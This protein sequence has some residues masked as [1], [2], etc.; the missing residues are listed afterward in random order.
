MI[1]KYSKS[2]NPETFSALNLYPDQY[3]SEARKKNPDW[4]KDTMDYFYNVAI[5]QYSQNKKTFYKNYELYKGILRRED[6]YEEPETK[7]FVDTLL[8]KE[9]L[10]KYV[11]HYSILTPPVN[12]LIGEMTKR[13]D[14][15]F[16]KAFDEEAVNEEI[17]YK[18]GVLEQLVISKIQELVKAKAG[19]EA[20]EEDVN[21]M[22]NEKA[23]ELL[24]SFTTTAEKWGSK[25]LE[26]MKTRFHLKD[27]SEDGFRDLLLS[28]REFFHVYEDNSSIGL[29]LEVINP[30]NHWALSVQDTRYTSDPLDKGVGV[31]AGGTVH[32]MELSEIIHK[33]KLTVEEIAHLKEMSQQGYLIN[34]KDSTL[35]NPSVYGVNSVQYNNYDPAVLQTRLL[36]EAEVIGQE[37]DELSQLLGITT[38]VGVFGNKYLVVRAY[39]CSKKK[40]GKLTF[41]DEDGVEQTIPVDENYKSGMH[42]NQISLE[43]GWTNQWYQGIRIGIDIYYVKPF[44]LFD[45]YPIIGCYYEIKNL[46]KPVSLIDQM[47]PF[48]ILYNVA[49]NK[50]WRLTEKDMGKVL[51]TS[52]RHIPVPKDAEY[53]D[54]LDAWEMEARERGVVFIDDSPENLKGPSS[55]NQH[56][57]VDLSRSQEIQGY[58][59]F[60]VEM[61]NECWKLVGLSEQRLGESKA[62]ET[63][64]GIN[65]ALSQSYAQ[66]EPWFSQHEYV[67]NRLYQ[68][69]LDAALYVYSTKPGTVI[70]FITDTGERSFIDT[71]GLN[72]LSELAVLV[73]SRAEDGQ[74]YK[75]LKMLAQSMLQNGATPYAIA[76]MYSTKS[77]SKI[78]ETFKKLQEKT[79]AFKEQQQQIEQ[80]KLEQTQQQFEQAQQIA[81]VQHEKDQA[82]E[83]YQNEQDRLSKEKIAYINQSS[84]DGTVEPN[85]LD[86]SKFEHDKNMA[87][88]EY[89]SKVLELQ[90][91]Q[92]SIMIQHQQNAQKLQIEKEKLQVERENMKNDEK[93]ARINAQNRAKKQA[94]SSKKKK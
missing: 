1:I 28:G 35:T 45:Y 26:F 50:L 43:W 74:N 17:E 83:A 76:Q 85:T 11:K 41:L 63:A 13:P 39:W 21:K 80:Q 82:F 15:I 53:A 59:K 71:N 64:T 38:N 73:T 90:Q 87:Y 4:I 33:F 69:L 51:L 24:N 20:N 70:P 40:I 10:P 56:T 6:F 3:V 8:Q 72:P 9:D 84:K 14:N 12:T 91:K 36:A 32:V 61:R 29:N 22:T 23:Q 27:K 62:T 92:Q 19:Q 31:Y 37:N 81:Q 34:S 47:K 49:M 88:Q 94:A 52:L 60:A 42:P 16:V 78:K 46:K 57:A 65:T 93:I 5:K 2:N 68:A 55:F 79:E 44:E 86:L 89:Q 54:A 25:M 30:V 48:Q 66:T 18:E 67:L 75:E 58:Y 77:I 7:S